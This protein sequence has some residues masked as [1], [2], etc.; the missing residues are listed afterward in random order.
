MHKGA[1][2]AKSVTLL[3]IEGGAMRGLGSQ[4]RTADN[5]T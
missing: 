2:G 3:E 5:D 1:F 4:K